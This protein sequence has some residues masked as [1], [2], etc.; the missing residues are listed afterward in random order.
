MPTNLYGQQDNF[1]LTGGHVLPALIRR[2][3]EARLLGQSEV[4]IW[5]T[6]AA[7]REFLHVDDL[8][9]ACLL[10]MDQYDE[11]EHINVGT[12]VD[13]TIAELA[14]LVRQTVYPEVQLVFD[15]SKPDGMPRKLLD[16]SK[17]ERL[18]WRPQISLADGISAT[19]K[20]FLENQDSS[21][22]DEMRKL[23]RF[24][25]SHSNY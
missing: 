22:Y 2:F 23:L 25:M 11:D 5:G 4:M 13:L 16:I 15:T 6:G 18:G 24:R 20:W 8:A 12:G 21:P 17:L 7:R 1:D 19:Y 10:L 3:H 9:D 14:D